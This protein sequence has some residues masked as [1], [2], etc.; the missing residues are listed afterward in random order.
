MHT[1]QTSI[2]ERTLC[3]LAA[4]LIVAGGLLALV[5]GLA[6]TPG[7]LSRPPL[8]EAILPTRDAPRPPDEVPSPPPQ[9]DAANAAAPR[10]PAPAG[11][12]A[13]AAQVA[14]P[15]PRLP[16]LVTPP[17]VP[18]A[19][20]AG[21]GSAD[22]SSAGG[23]GNGSG[24]GG[25]GTGGGGTGGNGAGDNRDAAVYPRQIAGKLHYAEIPKDLRK[26]R[27]GG[28]IRLRYRIGTDGRTSDCTVIVSSGMPDFDR[29]TCT[30]ITQ[31]FRFRPARDA[32]GDPVPFVMTETHGW[33]AVPGEE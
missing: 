2:P 32:A 21:T 11:R 5:F 15:A 22:R 12:K 4:L 8:L 16:P 31:R 7:P 25:S 19:P 10:R 1:V 29:D 33:D 27:A 17:R 3:A 18:I 24:G 9:H 26:A 6:F 30:R 23:S 14:L 28:V 20:I 13:D